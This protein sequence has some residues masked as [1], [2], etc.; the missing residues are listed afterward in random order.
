MSELSLD[1]A[2][3]RMFRNTAEEYGV[4][5]TGGTPATREQALRE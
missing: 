3:Q 4:V 1:G 2:K 5:V